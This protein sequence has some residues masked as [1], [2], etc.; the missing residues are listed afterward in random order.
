M[1][2][3]V[4][5]LFQSY[6]GTGFIVAWFFVCIV[7]LFFREEDKGK[8]IMFVYVPVI[9]LL[10]FFNPIIM[11]VL[12]NFIGTEIYYRILWLMPI[13]VVIA[14]TIVKISMCLNGKKMYGFLIGAV[15]MIMISGSCIYR[16][17]FFSKAENPEHMPK[18]VIQICDR[19]QIEGREVMAAFP[20]T[21]I[22]YVRQYTP[23]IC[24]PYG[25]GELVEGWSG[26]SDFY[27]AMEAEVL[28]VVQIT[29][30]AKQYQ[31]HYI[32]VDSNK[33]LEGNFEDYQYKELDEIEGYTIYQSTTMYF[34][35]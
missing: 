5:E 27:V 18:A 12:Y 34:G 10:L 16:S 3:S 13:V 24:M 25:R 33:E 1:W 29:N 15:I 23:L 8:R 14:Y 35:Y 9:L 4:V 20:G 17:P 19:I 11:R 31:C 30:F 26:C 7:Y 6:M 2:N 28:D 32:I 21:L 22:S